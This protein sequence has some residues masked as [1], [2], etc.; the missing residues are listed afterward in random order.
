MNPSRPVLAFSV[1]LALFLAGCGAP[2]SDL[3]QLRAALPPAPGANVIVISFDALR[4][5]ALGYHGYPRGTSPHLDAFAADSLV[6]E[7]AYTVAPVTPTSFAAAFT[8]LLPTR[9]FHRWNLTWDDTLAARFTA[10]GYRTAGFM[11]NLQLS[12]ERHFHTGFEHYVMYQ[13]TTD[14]RVVEES[15][16]WLGENRGE[17]LFAWIHFLNP[18]APYEAREMASQFYDPEYEGPFERTTRGRFETEDPREIRRIRNLYD[19]EVFYID[20]LF[21]RMMT[22]LEEMGLLESSI[23]VVTSDHGEEFM[24]HGGFQHDRLTEE[25]VHIPLMLRH[26]EV[27]EP[28]RSPVLVSNVDLLPTLLALVGEP[29][30]GPLDGRDLTSLEEDGQRVVGVSMT[31]G[32]KRWLSL[33]REQHK[34]ILTCLPE[35][36]AV[37]YDLEEDPG[38]TRD[39]GSERPGVLR[40]LLAELDT[41]LGGDACGVMQKAVSGADPTRGLSPEVVEGLKALG[42]LGD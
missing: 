7:R 10:A 28:L 22:G 25:H 1:F 6:F 2:P 21:D 23:V 17:R 34:L 8:G 3:D 38:E 4:A 12:E 32:K 35:Q 30:E 31:G 13:S 40:E 42:Y 19:G 20:S 11:N 18:H 14:E 33:R 15:L 29:V 5:D 41:I 26:P 27:E 36:A 16:T 39:Y 37:L 24:E 9:V